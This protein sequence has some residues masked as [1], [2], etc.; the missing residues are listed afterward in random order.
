[1]KDVT[2][3]RAVSGPTEQAR[4]VPDV[5]ARLVKRVLRVARPL[6]VILFGSQARGDTHRWSDV[7]L[8]V[9]VPDGTDTHRMRDDLYDAL[10]GSEVAKDIVVATPEDLARR[11]NLVGDILR[12]ALR[13]GQV[14]Y[15]A[16]T[17]WPGR[18]VA[19]RELEGGPVSE[20]ERLAATQR[21][22]RQARDDLR[23]AEVLLA[24][25][26][27]GPDPSCYM[28]QQAAEKALKALLVFLQIDYP[29]SH[30]LDTVRRRIPRGWLAKQQFR[31]LRR[32]SEW[33]FKAR[34]P[35]PWKPPIAAD[36][37]SATRLARVIY[38]AVLSDLEEHGFVEAFDQLDI[39][40]K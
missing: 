19:N 23:A 25:P 37:E 10:S 29:L 16:S 13:E 12:P 14:V 7:D 2:A 5:A 27:V 20:V 34:Y 32:L 6:R 8:L 4:E 18:L 39:D 15:D 35:G 28:S 38:E 24:N 40:V 21:W 31:G 3:G 17:Q 11:G 9:I 1:V 30:D 22:M 33:A 26:G 36:A